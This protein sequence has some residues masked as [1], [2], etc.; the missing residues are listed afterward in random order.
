M[1]LQASVNVDFALL[2]KYADQIDA[3]F[4][5]RAEGPITV[6]FKQWAVRYR[7]YTQERFDKFSK[8]G[9][10][11]APLKESTKRR[12]RTGKKKRPK[13][14]TFKPKK[15]GILFDK[16]TGNPKTNERNKKRLGRAISADRSAGGKLGHRR[17]KIRKQIHALKSKK[18]LTPNQKKRLAKLSIRHAN[19]GAKLKTFKNQASRIKNRRAFNKKLAAFNAKIK[20]TILRDTNTLFTVLTPVFMGRPGSLQQGIQ[21]GIRVGFGGPAAHPSAKRITIADIAEN[22]QLG[23]GHLP[24]RKIIVEPIVSVI[25]AMATDMERALN[26]LAREGGGND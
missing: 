14:K 24:V 25:N 7:A 9:G 18:K 8:G 19:L 22:H 3:Q 2:K 10:D 15:S 17:R 11:W 5:H 16:K 13:L 20:H 12:R 1:E 4:N 23:K 26:K 6:A 21:D